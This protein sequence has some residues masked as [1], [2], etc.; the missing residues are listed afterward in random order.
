MKADVFQSKVQRLE[1]ELANALQGQQEH[2]EI[3][4]HR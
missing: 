3:F 1:E 2:L 4:V